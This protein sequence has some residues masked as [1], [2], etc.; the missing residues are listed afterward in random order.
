[1][2][3][4]HKTLEATDKNDDKHATHEICSN[5]IVICILL[6]VNDTTDKKHAKNILII[7]V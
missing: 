4:V 2:Y 3:A 6:K 7:R 1:M 5:K